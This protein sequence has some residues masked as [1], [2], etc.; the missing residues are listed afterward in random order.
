MVLMTKERRYKQ[1]TESFKS[2][3]NWYRNRMFLKNAIAMILVLLPYLYYSPIWSITLPAKI[4][5]AYILKLGER[6][7]FLTDLYFAAPYITMVA[8]LAIFMLY[9]NIILKIIMSVILVIALLT[10][11]GMLMGFTSYWDFAIFLP[12]VLLLSFSILLIY[13]SRAIRQ[14]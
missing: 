8:W 14:C 13:K 6:L 7:F 2:F 11:I 12:Q 10:Q 3:Y 4:Q 1:M 5:D 9:K